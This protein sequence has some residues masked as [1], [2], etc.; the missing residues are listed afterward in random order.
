MTDAHYRKT[1]KSAVKAHVD[2][3]AGDPKLRTA[4][5]AQ[6]IEAL[7]RL[8]VAEID[9]LLVSDLP[10]VNIE[11]LERIRHDLAAVLNLTAI[12]N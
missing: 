8:T 2:W 4:T 1:L 7:T 3:I 10:R 6:P 9:K 5:I 11:R 12:L